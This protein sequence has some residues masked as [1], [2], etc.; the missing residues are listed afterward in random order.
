MPIDFQMR[1]SKRSPINGRLK[2]R[3]AS[4]I[5]IWVCS[6]QRFTLPSEVHD[7]FDGSNHSF[8]WVRFNVTFCD[9]KI[10]A[11]ITHKQDPVVVQA[12]W[13]TQQQKAIGSIYRKHK[14]QMSLDLE[15]VSGE[16]IR[17]RVRRKCD[18]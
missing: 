14:G 9:A 7:T 17:E 12:A 10:L 5:F 13:S 18:L 16:P 3:T 2:I 1:P 15:L 8:G 6:A 4:H 11:T